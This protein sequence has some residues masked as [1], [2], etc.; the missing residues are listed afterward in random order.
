MR[1]KGSVPSRRGGGGG[2]SN[3]ERDP[4]SRRFLKTLLREF[5]FRPSRR[6]GQNFLCDRRIRDT[7]VE[8]AAVDGEFVLEIGPGLG[9]LTRRLV[10]KADSVVGVEKSRH[11]LAPLKFVLEGQRRFHLIEKDVL[12]LKRE[13]IAGWGEPVVVGNLPYSVTTPILFRFLEEELP[14]KRLVVTVQEEV[15][16]RILARPGR[17]TY[18]ALTIAVRLRAEVRKIL[19]IP[20]SAFYPV[21]EVRSTV[22]EITPL[23][24]RWRRSGT[25]EI[26]KKIFSRRRKTFRNA[27]SGI[28]GGDAAMEKAGIN[29]TLR[30]EEIDIERYRRFL[31][32]VLSEGS[33]WRRRESPGS[34]RAESRIKSA[35]I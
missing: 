29:P 11:L 28:E 3:F 31:G 22:L 30:P 15:G 35:E 21:P 9:A 34:E 12:A 16:K 19:S 25:E 13:E 8:R 17:S 24:R 14:W 6:L 26:L 18:G 7:F 32:F 2:I 10:E 20:P 5:A 1:R 4:V 33:S 23:E 27:V